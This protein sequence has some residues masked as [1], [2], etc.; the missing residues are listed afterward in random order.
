MALFKKKKNTSEPTE[1]AA[2]AAEEEA[3]PAQRQVQQATLSSG[4]MAA[5]FLRL[6]R[7]I[8]SV[9]LSKDVYQIESGRD[10]CG[11]TQLPIRGY[12]HD[13][14][15]RLAE[16]VLADQRESFLN[17]FSAESINRAAEFGTTCLSGI[18][19][20]DFASAP[21]SPDDPGPEE[22]AA[23]AETNDAIPW[24]E[25]R[26]ELLRE[27]APGNLLFILYFRNI[28]DDL[29]DGRCAPTG[30][31]I[32]AAETPEQWDEIRAK[33]LLGKAA[34]IRF[35]YDIA[36]DVMYAHRSHDIEHGDRSTKA[37]LTVLSSRSDWVVHHDSVP[38]VR[39]ILRAEPNRGIE[40]IE[41]L[42]R[43]NGT[44]GAAFRHYRLTAVPLEES[45]T[46]TWIIG[47]LED[48]EEQSLISRQNEEITNEL[49]RILDMYQISL[50][51]I[52]TQNNQIYDIIQDQSGFH[53]GDKARNLTEYINK[54]I[55]NGTI[56]P[57][58]AQYYRQMLSPAAMNK[59][60]ARGAWEFES[61]LRPVGSTEY[62]WYSESILPLGKTG[63]RY[64]RWRSDITE[65]HNARDKEFELKE[66]THLAEYN[67]A[68]LDSMAAL[69]EFRN[70]ESSHH[71]RNVR[72]LTRILFSDVIRR[73]PQYELPSSTIKLY[74]QA[75]AMHDIGKITIPD[76]VLN[77]AGLY[78]PEE[79]EIMK[80]H[81]TN[82]AIIVDRLEMPGQDELKA[83]VR[84]VALH[85]HERW[86][87]AG[88]P[89]GLSGD[90]I[91]IGVQ[92]ISLA[93]VFD[94]L[95]SERCYKKS[96]P[97]EEAMNMILNGESGVFNPALLESLK[98]SK[99]KLS[100]LYADIGGENDG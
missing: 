87:G 10:E 7:W 20:A 31:N 42:Y 83:I 96:F 84:D 81:T 77:K 23:S 55:E 98:A 30:V 2:Q 58:S 70:I 1:Q 86:D 88:Y 36:N 46:P 97:T 40:T 68:I 21:A 53:R 74:V 56:A 60:T 94:A 91:P 76:S 9:S 75:S 64:I 54:C 27:S 6:Y 92:I 32:P 26:V 48:V 51:E 5:V 69:V 44:F 37:F 24:Y 38:A 13:L 11:G 52:R 89:D 66:M 28:R 25:V 82:G 41:I 12:Y 85:H 100:A 19:C 14:I 73:S 57:D 29:D 34:S 35:E 99:D 47:M 3:Q 17:L 95:V 22:E 18:F 45:G 4:R 78:T 80:A 43:Q 50:Y 62:R 61:Q 65:A 49:G 39:N 59:N 90:D 79:Y 33:R 15:P 8:F 16:H 71:I 72:E 67:G 63:G 93:D